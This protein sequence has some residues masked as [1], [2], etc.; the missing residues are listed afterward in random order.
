MVLISTTRACAAAAAGGSTRLD[1]ELREREG[2]V[3][4][5]ASHARRTGRVARR[6]IQRGRIARESALRVQECCGERRHRARVVGRRR[7]SQR[8]EVAGRE[9]RQPHSRADGRVAGV[10]PTR[11]RRCGTYLCTSPT[12]GA[13]QAR[14]TNIKPNIGA[15]C[16]SA[17]FNAALA[18]EVAWTFS[19][20]GFSHVFARP[21]YQ[22]GPLPAGS[23][24]IP[25]T[26]RGVPDI[27]FQASAATGALVYLSLRRTVT[28][29][30][31]TRP[32]GT[33]SA[34]RRSPARSGQGSLR[35]PTRSTRPSTG[36]PAWV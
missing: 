25:A 15:K 8:E 31:S 21:S 2:R 18:P 33:T 29:V 11:D 9:W 36:R 27:A 30:T 32:S 3:S 7:Y 20:G 19:G 17:T 4:S 14:T 10:G 23:T 22:A 6:R 34:G 35:L 1:N 5:A 16:G 24:P 28:A 26:A 12:A 13:S